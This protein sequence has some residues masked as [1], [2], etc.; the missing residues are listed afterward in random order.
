MREQCWL[1]VFAVLLGLG[2]VPSVHAGINVWTSIGPD[3][4]GIISA[5]AL[6]PLTPTTLYAGTD[7]IFKSTDGGAT[8]QA[9]STGLTN[10][11][12]VL[13]LAIDPATSTTLYA[14]AAGVFKS[15]DGGA[16]WHG[17]S[18]GLPTTL[19]VLTLATAFTAPTTLY[20]GT[21]GD[22]AFA[23]TIAT[24]LILSGPSPCLAGT[25]NTL[26]VIG[27]TPFA[28]IAFAYGGR[29]GTT[30]IPACAKPVTIGGAKLA[31]HAVADTEGHAS[32][33]ASVP[34][35]VGG[36]TILFQAVEQANCSIST[37]TLCTFPK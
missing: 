11:L 13:T 29:A 30:P 18:T 3:G 23:M 6:D 1:V 2:G 22:S 33:P 37:M 35:T 25:T 24:G 8:W 20:A 31:G 26:E 16:T 36:R 12:D 4:G 28:T 5:L 21:S 27:A 9:A 14:G 15:I 34:A 19:A 7:G 10:N 32:F 17:A